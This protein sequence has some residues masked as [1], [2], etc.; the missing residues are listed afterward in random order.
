MLLSL[1]TLHSTLE[2]ELISSQE[3]TVQGRMVPRKIF[4]P[5]YYTY[6]S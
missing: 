6:L 2:N 4:E 3:P 1:T 5:N